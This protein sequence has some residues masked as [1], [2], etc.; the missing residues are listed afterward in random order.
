MSLKQRTSQNPSK[1]DSQLSLGL[2]AKWF[3]YQK[4]KKKKKED[5]TPHNLQV[6]SQ[7]WT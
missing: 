3:T 1:N 4:E 7:W 2:T 6:M 5:F